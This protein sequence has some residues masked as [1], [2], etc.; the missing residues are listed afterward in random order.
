MH[1]AQE[2]FE[3]MVSK[4]MPVERARAWAAVNALQGV[5]CFPRT[6]IEVAR[7]ES[8][9]VDSGASIDRFYEECRAGKCGA[10]VW[11]GD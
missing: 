5:D 4:G 9:S 8:H 1:T 6:I 11:V 3:Y 7:K 10:G 2:Q